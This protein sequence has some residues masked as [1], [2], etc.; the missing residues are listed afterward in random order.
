MTC[1]NPR[2][3]MFLCCRR[4]EKNM[5]YVRSTSWR[6]T[7]SDKL[8]FCV[9]SITEE[10]SRVCQQQGKNDAFKLFWVDK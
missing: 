1:A 3:S 10:T 5:F 8:N 6:F 2:F 7:G 4:L 9:K